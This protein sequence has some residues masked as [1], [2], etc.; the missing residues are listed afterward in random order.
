MRMRR[1]EYEPDQQHVTRASKDRD[2][3]GPEVWPLQE[4]TML[5]VPNTRESSELRR[6]AKWHEPPEEIEEEDDLLTENEL[7]LLQTLV[8][9]IG[10]IYQKTL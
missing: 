9:A 8:L 1:I 6:T 5:A 10:E 4:L 2:T 3:L 7:K